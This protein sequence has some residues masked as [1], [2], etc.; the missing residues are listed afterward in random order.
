[1]TADE[2]KEMQNDR[3]KCVGCL[4]Q[5]QFS[6]WSRADGVT[7]KIPDPRTY[8]IHKTLMDIGHGGSVDDNLAFAGHSV[9]RFSEDPLYA[10]G[11]I[12]S[13]HDLF[14]AILAGK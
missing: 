7:G 3:A 9:Y 14:S 11:N 8:C 13:V 10:N 1:L 5:C 12:P 2:W 6:A 4:S